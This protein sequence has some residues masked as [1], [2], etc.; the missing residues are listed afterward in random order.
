MAVLTAAEP[1]M[2][3]AWEMDDAF[4]QRARALGDRMQ[5]LG[6]IHRQPDYDRLFDLSFVKRAKE[7]LP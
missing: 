6:I 5:A 3:L 1:N 2:E 4:V 7:N